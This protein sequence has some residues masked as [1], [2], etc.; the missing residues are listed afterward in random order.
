MT[1]E[2]IE[3]TT[4]NR[5]LENVEKTKKRLLKVYERA[6]ENVE[7]ELATWRL[8]REMGQITDTTREFRLQALYRQIAEE[9]LALQRK[10]A[11]IISDGFVDT[12]AETMYR[13][14]YAVERE[15]NVGSG[16]MSGETG[17]RVPYTFLPREAI[18]ASVLNAE[19]AGHNF[20]DRMDRD[21]EKLQ[22]AVRESVAQA[23][24]EGIS[25]NELKKRLENIKGAMDGG[26]FQSL[27]TARTELLRAYSFAHEEAINQ[28]EE[29]GVEFKY[30]WSSTLDMKTRPDHARADGQVAKKHDGEYMFKVGGVWTRGPRMS[31]VAKQDINCRCRKLAIPFGV[32]PTARMAKTS[33]DEWK[34]VD[35]GFNYADYE[36]WLKSH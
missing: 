9:I 14:A 21:R 25:V 20:K 13:T 31:G 10:T 22:W 33:G 3:S 29:A 26:K 11:E 36:N 8:G 17:Y 24:A 18:E 28:A 32:E 5:A 2:G 7:K 12:Y 6:L 15:I 23:L 35:G 16:F 1:Y 19:I 34:Q 27:T 4:F 30:K